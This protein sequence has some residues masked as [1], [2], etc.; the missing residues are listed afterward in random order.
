MKQKLMIIAAAIVLAGAGFPIAARADIRPPVQGVLADVNESAAHGGRALPIA[1]ATG[2]SFVL[3]GQEF[4]VTSSTRIFSAEGKPMTFNQLSHCVGAII[5]AWSKDVGPYHVVD[6][7]DLDAACA[8]SARSGVSTIRGDSGGR[9]DAAGG[10]RSISNSTSA[11]GDGF[12][13][14][15]Q[16]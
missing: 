10:D 4:F 8:G 12:H 15:R 1:N 2:S 5:R 9:V 16:P 14:Q 11:V 3:G 13:H 7:V 6:R